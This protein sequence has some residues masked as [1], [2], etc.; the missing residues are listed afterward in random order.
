MYYLEIS[1]QRRKFFSIIDELRAA[2]GYA[3]RSDDLE[4]GDEIVVEM[5]YGNFDFSVVHS[6]QYSPDKI[7]IECQFGEIPR[8]RNELIAER[9]LQ[10]NSVLAELDS[11]LFCFDEDCQKVVYVMPLALSSLTGH[12]L[13]SKMTEMVWHGRRWV[14]TRYI[15]DEMDKPLELLNPTDLA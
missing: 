9:L 4:L 2:L 13:L 6:L 10:I 8:S 1:E 7:L 5:M 15:K 14:E 11:S 12:L 3:L